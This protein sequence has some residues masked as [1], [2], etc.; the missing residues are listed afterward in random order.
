MFGWVKKG[1]QSVVESGKEL[2][3]TESLIE[4]GREVKNAA[5]QILS[6]SEK[7]KNAKKE[8]F[9]EAML[10]QGISEIDLAQIYKNYCQIVYISII[11]GLFLLGFVFYSLFVKHQ[12]ISAISGLV[13]LGFCLANSFK[14]S[15]RSFQIKHQ[16]L[17]SVKE[18]YDRP[19]EWI[20]K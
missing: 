12:I 13:F 5:K 16:K 18:W 9:K 20:P 15:F 6:P 7:I 3:G 10:R 14:F 19:N 2:I 4:S 17:C 11:M 8:T 1:S